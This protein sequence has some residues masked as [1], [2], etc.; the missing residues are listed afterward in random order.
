MEA[1]ENAKNVM[2]EEQQVMQ[3]F[4]ILTKESPMRGWTISDCSAK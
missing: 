1:N 3:T 2:M 4:I